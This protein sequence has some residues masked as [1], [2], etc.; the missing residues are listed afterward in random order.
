MDKY[1][2]VDNI[3]IALLIVSM[4]LLRIYTVRPI[5]ILNESKFLV[6]FISLGLAVSICW[7][8]LLFKKKPDYFVKEKKRVGCIT[9]QIVTIIVATIFIAGLHVYKTGKKNL[10]TEK[11]TI[12]NK[13]FY[14][15]TG[16]GWF[17]I[18]VLN[19]TEKID[20]RSSVY[21]NF[22]V[23]D[24]VDLTIGKGDWDFPV[25]YEFK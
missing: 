11:A 19:N 13:G 6:T 9:F 7:L 21:E 8:Y 14:T 15:K 1:K 4:T 18:R 2:L 20:V 10:L 24:T 5:V 12:L 17:R 16:A 23:G 3:S 22:H 25:I